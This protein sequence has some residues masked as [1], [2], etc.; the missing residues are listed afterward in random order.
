VW[1][2]RLAADPKTSLVVHLLLKSSQI[3]EDD[4]LVQLQLVVQDIY[5]E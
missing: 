3:L 2:S 5:Q 1:K 4:E